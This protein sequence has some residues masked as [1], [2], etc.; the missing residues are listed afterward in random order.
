MRDFLVEQLVNLVS[1]PSVSGEEGPILGYLEEFLTGLGVDAVRQRVEDG[2]YNL[3]VNHRESNRLLLAAHVD[4]VP[5]LDGLPPQPVLKD[6]AVWGLGA[7]DDK[8]GVA[9][10]MG[11]VKRFT[12]KLEGLPVSFAFLVDEENQ[13][14][15][16]ETL[17][18]EGLPPWGIVFEPTELKICTCEAGSLEVE[19]ITY[20]KM[21][22]GSEVE[23]GENAVDKALVVIEKLKGLSFLHDEDPRLGRSLMNILQI[24][25]GDGTLRVP[26]RCQVL[27]DFRVLPHQ[28]AE[29]MAAE[30]VSLLESEGVEFEFKD[31]SLP[32]E[33]EPD[34]WVIRELARAVEETT[35]QES[36]LAGM[37]SWTDAAHLL[38]A[39]TQ[40]VVFGPGKL[41]ICHT[42]Q[43][44]LKI[45]ELELAYRVMERLLLNLD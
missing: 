34:A 26:N 10:L 44:M 3:L 39:G 33:I 25:G 35:E 37:R 28:N 2:W 30:I 36:Q 29:G 40:A 21:V 9:I 24:Q 41:S 18:R 1:I 17:A 15:G 7:C 31:V 45:D 5:P 23:E 27:L 22:H 43:E 32:F 11:L 16:S 42:P 14:K 8:A 19:L 12:D 13:G 38:E 20:G 4:T 6:E